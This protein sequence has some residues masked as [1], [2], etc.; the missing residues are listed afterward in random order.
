MG[1]D[2]KKNRIKLKI[3]NIIILTCLII[4]YICCCIIFLFKNVDLFFG[5]FGLGEICLFGLVG[6]INS[7]LIWSMENKRYTNKLND[8]IKVIGCAISICMIHLLGDVPS[9]ILTGYILDN[10]YNWNWTFLHNSNI[11]NWYY[12]LDSNFVCKVILWRWTNKS[13]QYLTN[14]N[15]YKND[16]NNL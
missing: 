4:G 3:G 10:T 14:N 6:P 13:I 9:P 5:L 11:I 2:N 16:E 8:E 1:S 12:S 15:Y 7:M